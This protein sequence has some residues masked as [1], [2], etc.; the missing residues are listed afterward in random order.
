MDEASGSVNARWAYALEIRFQDGDV[1]KPQLVWVSQP[2]D[3]GYFVQAIPAGHAS[4][5]T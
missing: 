3:R 2:I 1:I 4:P 5:A